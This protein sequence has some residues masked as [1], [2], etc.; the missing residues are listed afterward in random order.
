[1]FGVLLFW[2]CDVVCPVPS[3]GVALGLIAA[4][5]TRAS[6]HT[7][8]IAAKSLANQVAESQLTVG[9]MY[10]PLSEI[11]SV[12]AVIAAEVLTEAVHTGVAGVAMPADP[13]AAVQAI[14][15][16]P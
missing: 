6:D 10:P 3:P 14:M 16:K 2:S 13:H 8:F 12:S 1:M 11:R 4:K 9:C 7:F 5:A 15:Y